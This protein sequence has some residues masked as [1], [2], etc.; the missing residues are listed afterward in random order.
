[1]NVIFPAKKSQVRFGYANIERGSK[2]QFCPLPGQSQA[3]IASGHRKSWALASK[4]EGPRSQD[5][6]TLAGDELSR[7]D[8]QRGE[9]FHDAFGAANSVYYII[10]FAFC[11]ILLEKIRNIALLVLFA[12]KNLSKCKTLIFFDHFLTKFSF[13]T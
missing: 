10:Y 13:L 11:C 7:K 1:M 5:V 2:S 12:L 4:W 3:K 8:M 6:T 9:F